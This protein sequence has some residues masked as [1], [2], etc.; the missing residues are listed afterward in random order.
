[1]TSWLGR[2]CLGLFALFLVI[3]ACPSGAAEPE[4]GI[5]A[6]KEKGDGLRVKRIDSGEVI[7]GKRLSDRFG[8]AK[9]KSLN[10]ENTAYALTLV[11]A[12]PI[13]EQRGIARLALM[14]EG[15]CI[16]AIDQSQVHA[17]DTID[18]RCQVIGKEA[19]EKIARY[20][21]IEPHRREHPGHR[22]QTRWSAEKESYKVGE[23]VTVHMEIRNTGDSSFSFF[24][25]GKQRGPRDNQFRFL[26]YASHG[27]G[28]AVPDT[29]DPLN[30]GGIGTWHTLKPGEAYTR[31]VG[32]EDWFK[33]TE[34]DTYRVSGLF[35]MTLHE[36]SAEVG[37]GDAIWDDLA[38]GDC[39]VR[40]ASKEE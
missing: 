22:F 6:I 10:N 33:F 17:D 34:S 19:S 28:K 4:N 2:S 7:L 1:M 12:G 16:I 20:L 21:R 18:L 24:V 11:G 13:A 40:I 35:E 39:L 15:H 26:A 32:L 5:Y 29:G 36:G 25:G 37:F 14:I 3:S 8:D 30:F 38:V 23:P 27:F 9:M 31:S